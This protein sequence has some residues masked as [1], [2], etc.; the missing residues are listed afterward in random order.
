M[1]TQ[2]FGVYPDSLTAGTEVS[3]TYEARHVTVTAA[4]LLT[5]AG[6]GVATKGLPCVFGIAGDFNGV[7]VCFLTGT[8][9][10]LIPIDTEGIWNLSVVASDDDGNS[11]VVGGEQLYIN[12]VTGIVSKISAPATQLS[13]GYAL[14]QITSGATAVIAVKVHW[15][16]TIETVLEVRGT[17]GDGITF[18]SVGKESNPL[19]YAA[20][21]DKASEVWA[22]FSFATTGGFYAFEA[23]VKYIPASSGYGTPVGI[24]GRSTLNSGQTFTGGQAAM[25]GVRGHLHMADTAT[26]NQPSSIFCGL[27][28]VLTSAGTPVYTDF[29]TICC[30]YCDNLDSIDKAG[31]GVKGAYLASFQ[32]HG[33]TLDAALHLRGGNKCTYVF[34]F[35]T[36]VGTIL[37]VNK[38]GGPFKALGVE[39]DGVQFWINAYGS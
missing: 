34:S 28:G 31:I 16:P 25:E 3:S 20:A 8:T 23:D 13:F 24:V 10:D 14:G 19:V 38:T 22:T 21:S 17:P 15:D 26:L 7:G 11:L 12:K 32:N 33:G 4:E 2:D 39:I 35:L 5:S 6:S 18:A 30:I 37:D 27:R 9:T 29:D 36:F 1:P